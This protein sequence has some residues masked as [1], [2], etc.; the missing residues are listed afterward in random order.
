M[1]TT[2]LRRDTYPSYSTRDLVREIEERGEV[3]ALTKI[4]EEVRGSFPYKH[5][6]VSLADVKKALEKL[7]A[8]EPDV[9]ARLYPSP[10]ERRFD[11]VFKPFGGPALI[12]CRGSDY[13]SHN[14]AVERYG[15]VVRMSAQKE[16]RKVLQPSPLDYFERNTYDVVYAA[17]DRYGRVDAHTLRESVYHLADECTELRTDVCVAVYRCFEATNILDFC[18]ARGSQLLAAIAVGASYYGIDPDTTAHPI[19][20]AIVADHVSEEQRPGGDDE[21]FRFVCAPFEDVPDADLDEWTA[22]HGLFDLVYTS[23]PYYELEVYSREDTQSIVRYPKLQ[24][25]LESFMFV[26]MSKAWRVLAPGGVMALVLTDYGRVTYMEEVIEYGSSLPDVEYLGVL[27]YAEVVGDGKRGRLSSV[28]Q[29]VWCFKK[30]PKIRW[31]RPVR[32]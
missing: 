8:Y 7:R 24:D 19:Y 4:A 31:T 17:A 9:R 2:H 10:L 12:V 3:E 1:A 22:E 11:M 23:P 14:I 18:A 28:A 25:W 6:T 21:H 26:A 13:L 20:E 29:P 30:K 27:S 15:D 5:H 32:P 16:V